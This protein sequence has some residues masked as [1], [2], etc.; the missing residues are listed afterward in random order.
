[1]PENNAGELVKSGGAAILLSVV[2]TVVPLVVGVIVA[3]F[4]KLGIPVDD[5]DVASVVNGVVTIVVAAGYY[6]LARVLEVVASSKFG[7]LLG[8]AKAPAYPPAGNVL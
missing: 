8:Y 2:R 4:T 1:M 3:G 6:L 7:W 5:Q